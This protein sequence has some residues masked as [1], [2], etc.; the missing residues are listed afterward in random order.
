MSQKSMIIIGGGLA[1]LATGCYASM[2]GYKTQ[3]FEQHSVPGGLCTAWK[4]NGYTIDGCIHFLVGCQQN[5]PF[6]SL[7]QELGILKDNQYSM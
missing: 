5:S 6:Y 2:N 3:I 1:G 4:R 7:Y